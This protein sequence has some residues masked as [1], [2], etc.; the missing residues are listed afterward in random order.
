MVNFS[1]RCVTELAVCGGVINIDSAMQVASQIAREKSRSGRHI[2]RETAEDDLNHNK[3]NSDTIGSEDT[4][5][6]TP[7][8]S[9]GYTGWLGAFLSGFNRA[10]VHPTGEGT[11]MVE[12]DTIKKSL[13]EPYLLFKG[14]NG[15]GRSI[16]VDPMYLNEQE[17]DSLLNPYESAL[18]VVRG[19]TAGETE[20]VAL[21]GVGR[22]SEEE[23]INNDRRDNDQ[24]Y[25]P[26]K[27]WAEKATGGIERIF[28]SF[29]S[30]TLGQLQW[31]SSLKSLV[32]DRK[33]AS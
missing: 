29:A 2:S 24:K 3:N 15:D 11:V 17:F 32:W 30:P 7:S 1:I 4:P 20:N 26:V 18:G 19:I 22:E 23:S 10:F 31:M 33:R 12:S 27:S 6:L 8:A 14:S 21:E 25:I 16:T 28:T 13:H 9:Q 5:S